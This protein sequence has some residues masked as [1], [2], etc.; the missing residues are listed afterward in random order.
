MTTNP[1]INAALASAYIVI[2][3]F[4]ITSL[5]EIAGPDSGDTVL[6][7]IAILSL[8]VLSVAFMAFTFFYRPVALLLDGKREEAVAFFAR[9]LTAFALITTIVLAVGFAIFV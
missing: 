1:Y 7:P 4:G 3:V 2:V 8:L 6:A 9:T 5:G